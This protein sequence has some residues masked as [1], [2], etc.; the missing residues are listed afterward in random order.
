MSLNSRW[1]QKTTIRPV[2][3][4]ARAAAILA[5]PIIAVPID[6]AAQVCPAATVTTN[7]RRP[8]GLALSN[9]GNLIVSETGLAMP[10]SGRISIVS[11]AGTKRTLI[12]RLPSA[13]SD[14]GDPAGPAGL[15]MRGRTLY[16]LMSIGDT[17]L[18]SPVPTRQL[19][20]PSPSSPIFSS[21]LELK[22]SAN[23]EKSTGGFTMSL[24]DQRTLADGGS[25]RLSNGGGDTLDISL[26]TNFPD[27]VADPLP[28]FPAI[29][30]GSNPFGIALAGDQLFVTDGGRNLLWAVDIPTGAHAPLTTFATIPNPL[31]V[32]GPVVE[33]VPTGITYADGQLLV[34]LFRGV[35]FAPNTS[36]V[37]QID[38]ATGAQTPFITGLKTAIGVLKT[39]ERGDADYLVLQHSSG[40]LPFFAGPGVVLRVEAPGATP[41]LVANCFT[42]PTAM[43]LDEKSGTL[44]VTELLSGN[45]LSIVLN[46]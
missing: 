43:L 38:P 4:L 34:T 46:P 2:A 31:P 23:V 17:V 32:G 24:A 33:A 3:T 14:V 26:V 1:L 36:T 6:V 45:L 7:L 42:R 21:V 16:L 25:V 18:P 35:P 40:P 15:V 12:D 44:Y 20:N 27:Y 37:M 8:M 5:L 39:H 11:P 19:A 22:F 9:Q 10:N 13:L 29:V 28:G 30:R 41:T